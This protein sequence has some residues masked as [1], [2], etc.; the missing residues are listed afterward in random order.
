M[1]CVSRAALAAAL[2][3][4]PV[5]VWAQDGTSPALGFS[6]GLPPQP[7]FRPSTT[8]DP[9][10]APQPTPSPAIP[11]FPEDTLPTKV[12]EVPGTWDLSRDGTNRRCVMTLLRDKG[13]A[14][15]KVNFPAGCRRA[16]P[17][18]GNVAGW[19]YS[20]D[21]VRLVD[22]NVRP[23]LLFKRRPDRRSYAATENGDTYSLVPLDIAAM[24]PPG[25]EPPQAE[26]A[27]VVAATPSPMTMASPPAVEPVVAPNPVLAQQG[28]TYR[29]DRLRQQGTCRLGL[30][31]D[32]TVRLLP[33][34]RDE[35]MEVFN[36]V[37]WRFADGRM[38]VVAKR[39]HSI[40]FVPNG[41]GGWRRDPE[42]G[43]TLVL[44]RATP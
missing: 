32:G 29:V 26:T 44:R 9:A 5:T 15:Q 20:E 10:P 14:G 28:G 22:A 42:T 34:C 13:A 37:S 8:A 31:A 23:L 7:E 12:S 33:G 16:L 30:A 38:T 3:L 18:M 6:Q 25:A 24:R 11:A 2:A 21:A 40:D 41:D 1:T 39:G 36:P 43:V 27:A 35:G 19:L 17:F 4:A